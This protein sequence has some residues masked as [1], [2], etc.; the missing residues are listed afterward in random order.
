MKLTHKM[1][2]SLCESFGLF[3]VDLLFKIT[4][5]KCDFDVHLMNFYVF[6]WLLMQAYNELTQTLQQGKGFVV[7]CFQMF[8]WNLLP[9]VWPCNI[10]I[11][12][13][14]HVWFWTSICKKWTSLGS[15][16]K[17]QVLLT[18]RKSYSSCMA[19]SHFFASSPFKAS[20]TIWG[21]S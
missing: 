11:H 15:G 17:D 13:Q 6:Q 10:Q 8:G 1:F 20:S 16:T 21:F 14:P 3:H 4:I 9:Q 12:H 18:T 5:E 2:T 7:N 19:I